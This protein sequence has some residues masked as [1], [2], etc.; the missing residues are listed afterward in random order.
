MMERQ[1]KKPRAGATTAPGFFFVA[2]PE[3]DGEGE[4][5]Q[6]ERKRKKLIQAPNFAFRR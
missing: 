5:V 6:M 1:K 3:P 4:P 2:L